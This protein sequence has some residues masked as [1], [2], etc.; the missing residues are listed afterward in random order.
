MELC[1]EMDDEPAESLRV[2]TRGPTNVMMLYGLLDQE[3]VD[4]TFQ[5]LEDSYSQ[6]LVFTGNLNHPDICW[7]SNAV[8][9]KKSKV[10][11]VH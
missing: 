10:S 9:H 5:Q 3:E 8:G 4:E 6:A 2:R 1:I 7:L 11:V